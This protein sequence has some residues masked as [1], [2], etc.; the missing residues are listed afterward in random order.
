[1]SAFVGDGAWHASLAMSEL[2]EA[3]LLPAFLARA[4][5]FS[6]YSQGSEAEEAGHFKEA[7]LPGR[8]HH[9]LKRPQEG[10]QRC[11]GLFPEHLCQG[12]PTHQLF[13]HR[14]R[15]GVSLG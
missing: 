7:P 5:A 11:G 13:Q 8:L 15:E 10:G 14:Q 6:S 9:P 1:M 12:P 4:S 2:G 3:R